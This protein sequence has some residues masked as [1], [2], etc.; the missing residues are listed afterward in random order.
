MLKACESRAI[1][2][3]ARTGAVLASRYCATMC[4]VI[5]SNGA[6][7][8]ALNRNTRHLRL[9]FWVLMPLPGITSRS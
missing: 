6:D 3:F 7:S 8:N 4:G 1:S 9:S 5:A 2:R